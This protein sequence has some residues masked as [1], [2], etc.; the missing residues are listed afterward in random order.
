MI[1][2]LKM[3][4][5][6]VTGGAGFIGSHIVDKLVRLGSEVIVLDNL[7]TGKIENLEHNLGKIE[8]VKGDITDEACLVKVLKGVELISH[9]AALR[10]VPKSVQMPGEYHRVNVSG[11]L[12]LFLK[13]KQAGVKR[14][15]FASSSSLY[16]DRTDFPERESDLAKPV[17]PYAA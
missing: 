10:S 9:Q 15:A 3:R 14:I 12:N 2:Q 4:K 11:T 17:S 1:K 7:T 13:A 16:G 6:L 8:F 5:V